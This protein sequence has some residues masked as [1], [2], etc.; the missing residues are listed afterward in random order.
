[1]AH[2]SLSES[3]VLVRSGVSGASAV[4]ILKLLPAR[5]ALHL[6]NA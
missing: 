6:P 2:E 1:M 5:S 3:P 4:W